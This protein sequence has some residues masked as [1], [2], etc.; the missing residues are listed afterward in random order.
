MTTTFGVGGTI[1]KAIEKSARVRVLYAT[2]GESKPDVAK[3]IR[4]D[5]S[6]G[7]R[8]GRSDIGVPRKRRPGHPGGRPRHEQAGRFPDREHGTQAIFLPFLPH[9]HDDHR[10]VN[11]LLLAISKELPAD[12]IE[13]WAYHV[14]STVIP[15]VVVDIT[16]CRVR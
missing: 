7:A 10:R 14:Y 8:R 2:D 4:A 6:P 15:N 9:D 5:A 11:Q 12:S 13:A 3:R 1:L 16:D